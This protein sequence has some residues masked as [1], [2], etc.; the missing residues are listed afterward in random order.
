M[1]L[2]TAA[3]HAPSDVLAYIY[4]HFRWF[5]GVSGRW[6]DGQHTA[7]VR[8]SSFTFMG[9]QNKTSDKAQCRDTHEVKNSL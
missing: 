9:W 4:G 2:E 8:A 7:E 5:L 1:A 3:L 6:D